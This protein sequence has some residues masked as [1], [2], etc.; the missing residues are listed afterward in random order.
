[1]VALFN[2]VP[3]HASLLEG[4]SSAPVVGS[5]IL[6]RMC[7][8]ETQSQCLYQLFL[9][10]QVPQL[11]GLCGKGGG[12]CVCVCKYNNSAQQEHIHSLTD[13]I[14][15]LTDEIHGLID[16]IHGLTDHI[17]GYNDVPDE[18]HKR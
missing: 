17:H 3:P 8:G 2:G 5:T 15:S 6:P 14:H 16:H 13:H 9:P 10:L 7:S 1:M 4:G 12:A 11:G 18:T